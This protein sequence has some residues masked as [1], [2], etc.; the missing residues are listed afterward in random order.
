MN[1]RYKGRR[2]LCLFNLRRNTI[3]IDPLLE[4]E[5][6][7]IST[8]P[9]LVNSSTLCRKCYVDNKLQ[10]IGLNSCKTDFPSDEIEVHE[11]LIFQLAP[12]SYKTAI[13]LQVLV[14]EYF[15]L[16]FLPS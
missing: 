3:K 15:A 7:D 1:I 2:R 6:A 5:E 8:I 11:T 16:S 4:T 10:I 9:S 12:M 14:R 13:L